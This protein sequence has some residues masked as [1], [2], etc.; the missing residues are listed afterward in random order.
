MIRARL[1][2]PKKA[3]QAGGAGAMVDCEGLTQDEC[4]EA[5]EQADLAPPPLQPEDVS[6]PE[7]QSQHEPPSAHEVEARLYRWRE[8]ASALEVYRR[9]LFTHSKA[10]AERQKIVTQVLHLS[11]LQPHC[12]LTTNATGP[13]ATG[14][15]RCVGVGAA[16]PRQTHPPH[17]R[18]SDTGVLMSFLGDSGMPQLHH[19]NGAYWPARNA[20]AG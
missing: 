13:S 4:R 3:S 16:G 18:R 11:D 8:D 17:L 15:V 6:Q 9:V 12:A 14:A 19:V 1:L 5:V 10:C 7:Q 2:A 20:V